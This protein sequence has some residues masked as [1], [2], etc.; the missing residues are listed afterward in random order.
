MV[1]GVSVIKCVEWEGLYV[2]GDLLLE[3]Y[4]I[5][6]EDAAFLV[7]GESITLTVRKAGDLLEDWVC[8]HQGLPK[9]LE[10]VDRIERG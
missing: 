9:K 7:K 1:T 5:D 8:Q 4:E 2:D 10:E 3:E 6:L